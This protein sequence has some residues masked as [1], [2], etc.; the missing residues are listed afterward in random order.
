MFVYAESGNI[1]E[2]KLRLRENASLDRKDDPSRAIFKTCRIR[3][4]RLMVSLSF[5]CATCCLIVGWLWAAALAETCLPVSWC[6][7]RT[8]V[9]L[10]MLS[11]WLQHLQ[12]TACGLPWTLSAHG[13]SF[14][15]ASLKRHFPI[16][17]SEKDNF[18]ASVKKNRKGDHWTL[19]VPK[20]VQ[21]GLVPQRGP[22]WSP[23]SRYIPNFGRA[24]WNIE[25]ESQII[26]RAQSKHR[27]I[28]LETWVEHRRI[29][30]RV[31]SKHSSSTV[32]T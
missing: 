25:R 17:W 29:I 13:K 20:G 8:A 4:F 11:S 1:T 19:G 24:S 16:A 10:L 30:G 14:F 21:R 7:E 12:R 27:S 15:I 3:A 9:P 23:W 18:E 6:L 32:E 26:H 2:Y 22:I 31:Q 28:T 5:C